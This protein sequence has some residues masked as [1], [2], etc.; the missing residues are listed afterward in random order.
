MITPPRLLLL[1]GLSSLSLIQAM[2][3]ET[4]CNACKELLSD[5]KEYVNMTSMLTEN[6]I[7]EA[8]KRTCNSQLHIPLLEEVCEVLEQRVLHELFK[9]IEKID[10]S[11]DPERECQ[12]LRFCPRSAAFFQV[13]RS[14]QV[15]ISV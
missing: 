7:E 6:V 3:P 4:K 11:I 12:F 10:S 9:W 1:L 13:A 2:S 8:V 15:D 5:V 14:H